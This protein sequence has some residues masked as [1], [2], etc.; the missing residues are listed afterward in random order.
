MKNECC[1]EVLMKQKGWYVTIGAYL[2][3][4]IGLMTNYTTPPAEHSEAAKWMF[5]LQWFVPAFMLGLLVP[6]VQHSLNRVANI[7]VWTVVGLGFAAVCI[8][9]YFTSM[10]ERWFAWTTLGLLVLLVIFIANSN[11]HLR[12][13]SAWLLGAM[14]V[15][16]AMGS[17]EIIYQTGL[18]L[19]HNFFGW[20]LSSYLVAVAKQCT[21]IIPALIVV[22]VLYQRSSL[23]PHLNRVVLAC[24]GVSVVSTVIWFANGMDVPL[25]FWRVPGGQE[26]AVNEAARPWL[27]S[28]SRG[29]QAF[30]LVGLATMFCRKDKI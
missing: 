16:A 30:W 9:L 11:T 12:N 5:A 14:V 19:Y 28:V 13:T 4:H 2:A 1:D 29:S 27:I 7:R 17:W 15:L 22:L 24:L 6:R 20:P 21:W 25:V 3:L 26:V 8:A 18:W 10:L 23:R